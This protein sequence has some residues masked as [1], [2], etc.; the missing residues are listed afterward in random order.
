MFGGRAATLQVTHFACRRDALHGWGQ[1]ILSVNVSPASKDYDETAHVLKVGC[2]CGP[3][4]RAG[5]P[6][7][8][9]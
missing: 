9:Q 2:I 1:V 5:W 6:C 7:Q 8:W 4:R 3:L